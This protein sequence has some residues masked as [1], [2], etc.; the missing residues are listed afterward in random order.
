[1]LSDIHRRLQN[2]YGDNIIDTS[3]VHR[4]MKKFKERETSIEDKS[5]SGRP[6]TATTDTNR[7][8]VDA[9]IRAERRVTLRE[10]AAQL[11]CGHNATKKWVQQCTPEFFKED[12]RDWFNKF[13]NASLVMETM[14][15]STFVLRKSYS[16]NIRSSNDLCQ[17][18][19]KLCPL[20][21]YFRYAPRLNTLNTFNRQTQQY[22]Y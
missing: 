1:M 18:I 12:S 8:R 17:L 4:W 2:I 15:S 13:A 21:H 7:Q 11:D 5:R 19:K 6:S 3:N 20:L 10:L 9:S 16:T 22:I 14:S